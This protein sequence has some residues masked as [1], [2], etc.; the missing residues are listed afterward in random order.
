MG[1][2]KMALADLSEALEATMTGDAREGAIGRAASIADEKSNQK[3]AWESRLNERR[4]MSPMSAERMMT[5]IAN[6]LP[7]DAI[8][9]D[10]AVTTRAAIMGA[11]DFEKADSLIGISG[12]ALGWGMGGAM[13]A[14]L[15]NPDRPIVAVVGDG[16]SMMTVQALWTAANA[17][18]PVVYVICNN[19]SYRVLKLNMNIWKNDIRKD[20]EQSKYLNMDFP[21]PLNI[22]GIAEA[23]GVHGERIEKAEDIGPALK[24]AI[25]SGKPAVLDISIDGSV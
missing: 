20:D 3:S 1:D 11:M 17:N 23:I 10:D 14:K 18:I 5:E 7:D 8:I 22:A 2:P 19:Q 24:N 16:S 21:I 13:G 15:A 6:A 9:V 25:A 12:G 4:N